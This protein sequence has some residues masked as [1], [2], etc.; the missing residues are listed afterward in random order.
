MALRI[1]TADERLAIKAYSLLDI[2]A[3]FDLV[4]QKIRISAFGRN[5]TNEYYWTNV[6]D[7]QNTVVRFTGMPVT[8]GLQVNWR[9]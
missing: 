1:I 2:R 6:Q 8:Y 7:S 5:I 4:D 3:G 9:Y